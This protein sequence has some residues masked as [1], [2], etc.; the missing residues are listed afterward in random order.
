MLLFVVYIIINEHTC[1]ESVY[2]VCLKLFCQRNDQFFTLIVN[3]YMY[4]I[5]ALF[6]LALY[7]AGNLI[8]NINILVNQSKYTSIPFYI[9]KLN[10]R[11][12]GG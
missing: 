11:K 4:K 3:K 12:M 7:L 1:I 9:F 8:S 6:T 5:R 10:I 2:L